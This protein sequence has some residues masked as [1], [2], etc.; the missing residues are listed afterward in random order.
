MVTH[1]GIVP[2]MDNNLRFPLDTAANIALHTPA[3]PLAPP[4][5][6]MAAGAPHI[7]YCVYAD[8]GYTTEMSGCITAAFKKPTFG[9][10]SAAEQAFNTAM[11]VQRVEIEHSLLGMPHHFGYLNNISQMK[12]HGTP[13]DAY[14]CTAVLFTNLLNCINQSSQVS[15]HFAILPPTIEEYLAMAP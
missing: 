1:T 7:Q 12:L 10:L 4:A 9:T 5:T 14:Y 8:K 2:F 3:D 15:R 6:M 13:V 11:S